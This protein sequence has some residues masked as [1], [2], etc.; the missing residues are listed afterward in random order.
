MNERFGGLVVCQR[1]GKATP[2]EYWKHLKKLLML[3]SAFVSLFTLNQ[4][5]LEPFSVSQK[6]ALSFCDSMSILMTIL[7]QI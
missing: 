6:W 4:I 3:M 1:K 7:T 5:V 2:C